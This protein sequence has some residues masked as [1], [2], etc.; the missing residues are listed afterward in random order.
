MISS[1]SGNIKNPFIWKFYP[2]KSLKND[3]TWSVVFSEIWQITWLH[4]PQ[5]RPFEAK[6]K[7]SFLGYEFSTQRVCLSFSLWAHHWH[8]NRARACVRCPDL[9]VSHA[10]YSSRNTKWKISACKSRRDAI[11]YSI[12]LRL[13]ESQNAAFKKKI[14]DANL[15]SRQGLQQPNY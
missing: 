9:S 14:H 8:Q 1:R 11:Q 13:K 6:M 5:I 7:M 4:L 15:F 3:K 10:S 12:L 2:N